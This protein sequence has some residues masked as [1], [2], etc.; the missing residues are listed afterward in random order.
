MTDA[1][2]RNNPGYFSHE[3]ARARRLP[4]TNTGGVIVVFE[5]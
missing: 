1:R 4:H 5:F 3:P 2:R